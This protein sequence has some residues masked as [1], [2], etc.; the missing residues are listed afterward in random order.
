MKPEFL[1]EKNNKPYFL[2][3]IFVHMCVWVHVPYL[4][5]SLAGS[6]GVALCTSPMERAA[7]LQH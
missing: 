7:M 5:I 2:F 6:S 3:F 1:Q 4:H